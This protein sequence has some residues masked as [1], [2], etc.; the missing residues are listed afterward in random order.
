MADKY[1]FKKLPV[2]NT[3]TILPTYRCSA[4]CKDCCFGSNP[5]IQGRIPQDR[6]LKYIKD[7][8]M[9]EIK[10]IVFSGGEAFLL[11]E[12]LDEAISLASSLGMKTR[13]VSNGYWA[14]SEEIALKRLRK[15]RDNGLNEIN[16]STGDFHLEFVPIE[17]VINGILA[18]FKLCMKCALMIE[19]HGD[20]KFTQANIFKDSRLGTALENSINKELFKV[21][22]SPWMPIE[23]NSKI[24]YKGHE[25]F[26]ANKN[27]V[28]GRK[29]CLSILSNIIVDPYENFGCCCGLTRHLTPELNIGS[30]RSQSMQELFDEASEDFLKI[31]IFTDGP[32]KILSWAAE[33]DP[34]IDWENKYAHTC[35]AC[36]ALY[37]DPKVRSVIRE[38]YEE[39][40]VDVYF[41][42]WL[43][44]QFDPENLLISQEQF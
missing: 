5:S 22:E 27:N 29:R 24:S 43:L 23:S 32:E 13:I 42:Y 12:D 21:L 3:L 7:A 34:T 11:N 16:F 15:L 38:N 44:T 1:P 36:R 17:K 18:A 41:R 10:L 28:H 33:K 20:R 30:L 40:M 26:L 4:A 8:S 6:I 9:M 14:T 39:K 37:S 2:P 31:W 19:L 25:E 35:H